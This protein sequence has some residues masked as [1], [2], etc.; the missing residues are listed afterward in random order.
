MN[1]D[2]I[3]KLELR[4][5]VRMHD[6]MLLLGSFY[7]TEGERLQDIMNDDRSFLPLHA[8]NDSGRYHMVMLSKRYIQQ[9]EEVATASKTPEKEAYDEL[10]EDRRVGLDRRQIETGLKL[11]LVDLADIPERRNKAKPDPS[12]D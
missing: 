7:L 12:V 10:E 4:V 5:Y 8:L 11:E 3:R 9:V 6:G 2:A 1:Q